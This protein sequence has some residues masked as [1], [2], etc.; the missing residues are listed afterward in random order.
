M[1]GPTTIARHATTDELLEAR[2]GAG[3]AWTREH[4]ASC[5][6]CSAEV[7]HLDQM[8]A[9]L[10]SLPTIT[11]PRD[12]W[13]DIA[14][15]ARAERGRR[16][17]HAAAGLAAAATL[18]LLTFASVRPSAPSAGEQASQA[19]AL[20]RAMTRNRALEQTLK[21]IDP[22]HRV[23]PGEAAGVVAELESRLQVLDGELNQPVAR[24]G[25][26]RQLELWRER[27]GLMSALVDVHVTRAAAAGL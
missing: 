14:R 17:W 23:L 12:R 24:M 7:F 21:V 11:S 13:A 5:R 8:R 4:L 6:E 2:D 15:Q 20:E 9:R 18:T 16:R 27:A 26:D 19:A 10:R 25:R 22:E 1:N 3:S